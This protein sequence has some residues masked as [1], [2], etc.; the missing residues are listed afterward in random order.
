MWA[1]GAVGT[2]NYESPQ[3]GSLLIFFG[4]LATFTT[5]GASAIGYAYLAEIPTQELRARSNAWGQVFV[6]L[7]GIMLNFTVPIMLKGAPNWGVKT[8]FL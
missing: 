8:G 4:C 2:K 7:F 3:L 6:N 5:T 1:M